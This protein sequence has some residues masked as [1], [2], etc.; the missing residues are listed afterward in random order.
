M[1][2]SLRETMSPGIDSLKD[3][4]LRKGILYG[5]ATQHGKLSGDPEFA[6]L[7]AQ[8]CDLLVPEGE[9]KWNTLRPTPDTFNFGPWDQLF[10]FTQQHQMKYRGHTFVWPQALPKWF[11]GYAT[12]SNAES[13]LTT[14][15][16]KVMGHYAGKMQSWD[17]INEALLPEVHRS[18]GLR[19]SPW[20]QLL[21]PDYIEMALR[22]AAQADPSALLVWNET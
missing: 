11:A 14:H 6:A 5:A 7:F 21:G 12:K 1:R 22:A 2:A 10:A 9:L 3:L 4:A 20:L 18:D 16:S 19:N 17:V 13:L 15:I 8:Q